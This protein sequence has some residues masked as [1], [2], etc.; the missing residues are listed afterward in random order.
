MKKSLLIALLSVLLIQS[1]AQQWVQQATGFTAP[2]R[3]LSYMHAVN[4][5]V[6]WAAA[7]DGTNPNNAIQEFTRTING[8]TTWTPGTIPAAGC[9]LS[10]IFAL[11]ANTAWAPLYSPTGTHTAQGIYKTTD[12]GLNWTRQ[13]SATFN[14]AAGGFPNVV[15][16]FNAN[17]GYCQ[18]DAVGG[19]F[20]IYT[21]TNGGT[22][23]TR[24]PQANIPSP[25]VE[26]WGVVGYYSVVGNTTWFGTN[27]G[28]VFKSVDKG[29]TWTVASTPFA[30]KYIKP[31]FASALYGIVQD[32]SSN[33]T[34][35]I[36]KTE[37]G[38][39]TWTLVTHSGPLFWNDIDYVPGTEKTFVSTG[40]ATGFTGSTYSVDGGLTWTAFDATIGTQYLATSWVSNSIGWAGGFSTNATQ[41]GVFKFSGTITAP[42]AMIAVNP[43]SISQILVQGSSVNRTFSII[44][45][46]TANLQHTISIQ[47][48]GGAQTWLG[49]APNQG[50]VV[51]QGS[52]T[53][54]VSFNTTGLAF[55]IYNAQIRISSN[56]PNNPLTIIPVTFDVRGV[57]VDNPAQSIVKLYPTPASSI[58]NLEL[59]SLI[60]TVQLYNLTG[61]IISEKDVQ[62]MQ[63]CKLKVSSLDK[64]IYF[65][66]F[67]QPSGES[68]TRKVIVSR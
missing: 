1:T 64:G 3:G 10:M 24:V 36:A 23:W 19:Y 16:F 18:G 17:E 31:V 55:G 59:G 32:L 44:N 40:S 33:T 57:G 47:Y 11:D 28:R 53:I 39:S 60:R 2:S 6:V 25:L 37:D 38:G 63:E 58:L 61:Q 67:I 45:A 30:N 15:H 9:A 49:V 42:A 5:N 56:D 8:G 26:E 51:P 29:L 35:A 14:P 43:T 34:G 4:A 68:F 50:T 52:Q 65:I 41:G 12:G 62:E 66:R 20:E 7:Y 22:T 48:S 27:K 21:T 13:T 54:T 46:G